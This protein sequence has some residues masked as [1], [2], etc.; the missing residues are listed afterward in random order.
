MPDTSS[1]Q[2]D[3]VRSVFGD[4][5]LRGRA[6]GM[7]RGH[8]P[9]ARRAF[10]RTRL[11]ADSRYLD[12]G[13]GNGYTVRW[14]AERAPQ[15]VAVGLDVT[16]E[17]ISLARSMSAEFTTAEFHLATFPQH[18]LSRGVFDAIFSMEVFYYLPSLSA[19][20]AEVRELLRDGGR[21]VNVVDF[22]RENPASH[23]WPE[24][25]GVAMR[26]LGEDEW[27]VAFEEAGLVVVEQTRIRL[28][29]EEASEA[30]KTEV[31]SLLT[32]GQRAG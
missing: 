10:E 16:P 2:T 20:L 7:E 24:D 28:P 29:A 8:G 14:A 32:V 3:R 26:L 13:C 17:M 1:D 31:G 15:G 5:A 12:I 23:S 25:V 6:E 18:D 19:A 30:W 27:R 4:W 22:Y 21:F 11:A 9:V